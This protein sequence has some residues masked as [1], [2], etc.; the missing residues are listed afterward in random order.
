MKKITLFLFISF[1]VLAK[2]YAYDFEKD[3]ICYNYITDKTNEVEVAFSGSLTHYSGDVIVP[4]VVVYFGNSYRV[5]R[6]GNDAFA[7]NKITSIII[8]DG[9]T[10]IGDYAF[11]GCYILASV[12]IP[13]S[14]TS[15]GVSAFQICYTLASVTIPDSVISIGMLAFKGCSKL[16]SITIPESVTHIGT[17]LFDGCTKLDTLY[18]NAIACETVVSK[19]QCVNIKVLYIGDKV[20]K[21]PRN[22]FWG[23]NKLTSATI[24][25]SVTH[26]GATIFD[27]CTKLDTLY[28]NAIACETESKFACEYISA[29]YIGDKVSKIPY[30]IFSDCK[31]LTS[32]TIPNSVISIGDSA[33]WGCSGLTS[34][35]I[36]QSVTSI[37]KAAFQK[38]N[39]ITSIT[40]PFIGTSADA[41]GEDAILGVLFGRSESDGG[42]LQYYDDGNSAE[43]GI[44]TILE[45]ITVTAPASK[46]SYGALSGC[47]MLKTVDIAGTVNEI[48]EKA[49]YSC[50]EL[51]D[52]YARSVSPS[53]AS[54]SSFEGINKITCTVHV[55]SGSISDYKAAEGWKSF[56]SYKEDATSSMNEIGSA[57]GSNITIYPNPT[58]GIIPVS[59]THLTLPTTTR[60]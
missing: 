50:S 4:D 16:T 47:Y 31:I 6:I 18:F 22:L 14:V 1:S 9:V 32:V 36:P 58:K 2:T 42:I 44:P 45:K 38:C 57:Y 24:P 34:I 7:N 33:F 46:L 49:L 26:I 60:V 19:L 43:Y 55:P 29:L 15:I 20:T 17:S 51:G 41:T 5:T 48:G 21:I 8:P 40:L 25:E 10:S 27:G 23:C 35:A 56:F 3:G 12:S 11:S 59:Y 28:F 52:I 30:C 37:G 54:E 39:G 13:N 53:S